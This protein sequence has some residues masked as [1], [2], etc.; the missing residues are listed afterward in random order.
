MTQTGTNTTETYFDIRVAEDGTVTKLSTEQSDGI[1]SGA[2]TESD[3]GVQVLVGHSYD[4]PYLS[5]ETVNVS[6]SAVNTSTAVP[7]PVEGPNLTVTVTGPENTELTRT[8]QSRS[9]GPV[10]VPIDLSGLPNGT[11]DVEVSSPE[12][13]DTASADFLAGPTVRVYPH[14]TDHIEVGEPTTIAASLAEQGRPQPNTELNISIRRPNGTE[15]TRTVTT[16]SDGFSMINFTPT[17]SGPY[18]VHPADRPGESTSLTA[19]DVVAEL[20]TNTRDYS[21]W[22]PA[23][24]EVQLSGLVYDDGAAL[25]NT[26]LTIRIINTTDRRDTPVTNLSVSTNDDGLYATAWQTPNKPT[27]RYEAHLYTSD[28]ERIEHDGG[29]INLEAVD[30]GTSG[31]DDAEPTATL[32]TE[33]DSPSYRNVVAPG[34]NVTATVHAEAN[35]SAVTDTTVNYTLAYEYREQVAATGSVTTDESG[36]ATIAVPVPSDAPDSASFELLTQA[37]I[38]GTTIDSQDGGEIQRYRIEEDRLGGHA[39]GD[40]IGYELQFLDPA[41]GAGVSGV[42]ISVAAETFTR[43]QGG[44]FGTGT[45]V[46]NADGTATVNFTLPGHATREFL[47]GPRYPYF[48]GGFPTENVQ[49][50]DISVNG[51]SR[52]LEGGDTVTLNYTTTSRDDTSAVVMFR[53][54]EDGESPG[55]NAKVVSEGESFTMTAPDV[56]GESSYRVDLYVVN[57]S[58]VTATESEY[59]DITPGSSS[60]DEPRNV[61]VTG[62]LAT[63]AGSPAVNATVGFTPVSGG[64][65]TFVATNETGAYN[66]S[67][68]ARVSGDPL[69]ANTTYSV[70]FY[71]ANFVS[72]ESHPQTWANDGIADIYAYGTVNTSNTTTVSGQLPIGHR[73]NVTVTNESDVP[74]ENATVVVRHT[75]QERSAA[76][77]GT[78]TE[79]GA[80]EYIVSEQQGIELRGNVSVAV[81]DSTEFEN[82]MVT[83]YTTVT[84]DTAVRVTLPENETTTGDDSDSADRNATLRLVPS[85][86]TAQVNETVTLEFVVANASEGVGAF[87]STLS[88][89]NDTAR[90]ADASVAGTPEGVEIN[91]SDNN[92][93]VSLAAFGLNRTAADELVLARVNVTLTLV[94]STDLVVEEATLGTPSGYDYNLTNEAD[95]KLTATTLTP[96]GNATAPPTDPDG[97]GT[98][99][100]I[101]GDGNVTVSDVQAMFANRESDIFDD[102]TERFDFSGNGAVNIVDIQNLFVEVTE[103]SS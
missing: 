34:G 41:T 65:T 84:N 11:Y 51:L 35:G 45:D 88:L 18:W 29:R 33:I 102:H 103:T 12:T 72:G 56:S 47:Y 10:A 59:L 15:V 23:G 40:N 27:A 38:D 7:M 73:L 98:F 89:T 79:T 94:G 44:S 17:Q 24:D 60:A 70:A 92:T 62:Q 82:Q 80:Y 61:T 22:M 49:G 3:L 25:A 93:S 91:Q 1:V 87:S 81:Y 52:E 36:Q 64:P 20:K 19:V 14:F 54:W 28:G 48:D 97:D 9:T 75:R 78:T 74:V 90:I 42:P 39:P 32:V 6:V 43:M 2:V 50:Y 26:D 57:G 30:D 16:D 66:S 8:V 31:G 85:Q 76:A 13:S 63:A 68:T 69:T 100:D 86:D 101:N 55:A 46:S 77:A 67:N 37:T 96:I 95:A 4:E 71:Q 53:T 5:D 83:T 99:E 21:T 58:G